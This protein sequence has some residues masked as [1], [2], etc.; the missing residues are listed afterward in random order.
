MPFCRMKWIGQ[1]E[2]LDVMREYE[3]LQTC[4][5]SVHIN[6]D[7]WGNQ[8]QTMLKISPCITGGEYNIPKA[9]FLVTGIAQKI[10]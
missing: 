2:W 5:E 3:K 9:S 6:L 8:V 4:A 7:S 1:A 10:Y